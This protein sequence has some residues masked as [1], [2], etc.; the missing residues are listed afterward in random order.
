[1]RKNLILLGLEYIAA[2]LSVVDN[3]PDYARAIPRFSGLS[4]LI[5][6]PIGKGANDHFQVP[7]NGHLLTSLSLLMY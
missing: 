1:M 6:G 4:D 5:L 7:S 2:V 3:T